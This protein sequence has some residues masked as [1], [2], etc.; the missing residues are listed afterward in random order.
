M[1]TGKK[2]TQS[3]RTRFAPSP[4][5]HLHIGN[6]RTAIM[7]WLAARHFQGQFILRIEDTDRERSTEASERSIFKDL[8]WLDLD[9]DEGPET[10]GQR[11]P[12]RQSE[13]LHLY[14]EIL[15][16]LVQ[17]GQAYF[18]YCTAEELEKRRQAQLERGE[19]PHYDGRCFHLSD[20]EKRSFEKEGRKPSVRFHVEAASVAFNDLVKGD[21]SVPKEAISDFVIARPDGMPMYNFAC[22]VDD[23][24]MA[25]T[26]VIRGDDHVSNTPRQI[27]LYQAMDWDIPRYAHIPMILGKDRNRLSKRHG[28]TS[29]SQF[30]EMGY[31]PEALVNFLS[32]LS[33]S[34]ESGDEILSRDRL[35]RE[36]N[37]EKVS[38]SASV[39]D[40]EKLNWMNGIYIR[41]K[42]DVQTLAELAVPFFQH[43]GYSVPDAKSALPV[44]RVIQNKIEKLSEIGEQAGIFYQETSEPENDEAAALLRHSDSRVVFQ[45][46]LSETTDISVWNSGAFV[47]VLKQV[48]KKTNVKGKALW[49]PMRVAMTGRMHG[50]ELGPVAEVLGLKKCRQRIEQALGRK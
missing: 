44:I 5:G 7:N 24:W 26:H 28:A 1:K 22:V 47:S 19:Q 35:I 45:A 8:R 39:F 43:A 16:T 30:K 41:E 12:Y 48:Q 11:G 9:W 32:L 36:F 21:I 49:M 29:V 4:T 18:C 2:M 17:S 14:R 13:R 23:H 38:R 3:I 10:G 15:D 40:T 50:P 42:T 25:I 33:W 6:A 20:E 37:F 46:F 34:S 27:L 31:L